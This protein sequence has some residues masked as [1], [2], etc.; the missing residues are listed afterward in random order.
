[1]KK[2][3]L[4]L[5]FFAYTCTLIA[6]RMHVTAFGGFANYQGDIQEKRFTLNQAHAAFGIGAI[7]EITDK[8]AARANVTF[9]KLSGDDKLGKKNTARNLNFATGITDVHLGVEYYI[10]NPYE[11]QLTPYIFA[12]VSYF[13]FNPYT[14]DTLGRKVFLQPLSTEGQGFLPGTKNYK[15][16]QFA[17]P[18][19]GGV[20]FSLSENIRVGAEV[21]LRVTNT[22]YIDDLSTNYVD[23]GLLIANR[24][25][26]AVELAFR[27]NELKVTEP[28]PAAGAQRGS[29]KV[30][31]WY[32]FGGLTLDIRLNG[33]GN[34]GGSAGRTGG[35][36]K[37]GCPTNVY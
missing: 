2:Y 4:T 17:I 15:L 8:I 20:K 21:G 10:L 32:Y 1:M 12:G 11:R 13:S 3:I 14:F 36:H 16:H 35:R 19:G 18:V 29:P 6:Q 25:F 28:Y 24:G 5:S 30:K 27:S 23:Q 31:D 37:T 33:D 22:D 9:S 34:G 7:Y 26:R